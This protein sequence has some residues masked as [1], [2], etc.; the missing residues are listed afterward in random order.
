MPSRRRFI[1]ANILGVAMSLAGRDTFAAALP[2]TA[3]TAPP[4]DE[5][6]RDYWN[7]W[8]RYVAA[9]MNEARARRLA[10]LRA[11]RTEADV[12]ARIEKIRSTVWKLVGGPFEKTPLKPH[13]SGRLSNRKGYF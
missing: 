10:E 3:E 5:G 11:L 6:E 12:K 2:P 7:D 8:P 1:Q 4:K 13:R 9:Q